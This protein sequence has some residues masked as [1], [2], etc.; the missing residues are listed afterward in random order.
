MYRLSRIPVLPEKCSLMHANDRVYTAHS[1]HPS[2]LSHENVNANRV[3]YGL[4]KINVHAI[5]FIAKQ[6]L[7][8]LSLLNIRYMSNFARFS[9]ISNAIEQVPKIIRHWWTLTDHHHLPTIR[10][11]IQ[12]ITGRDRVCEVT[13]QLFARKSFGYINFNSR[14]EPGWV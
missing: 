3:T 5:I 1:R 7:S 10:L 12:W 13:I 2:T 4:L 14:P 11:I 9:R 8:K 6:P